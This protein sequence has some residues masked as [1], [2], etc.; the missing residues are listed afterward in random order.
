MCLY[1]HTVCGVCANSTAVS[2]PEQMII[3]QQE[4]S[5]SPVSSLTVDTSTDTSSGAWKDLLQPAID[6]VRM[7]P[8]RPCMGTP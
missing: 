6:G 4:T 1:V 7:G 3:G 8:G 2:F 5:W